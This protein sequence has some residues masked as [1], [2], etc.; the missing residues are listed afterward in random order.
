VNVENRN[1]LAIRDEKDRIIAEKD[2]RLNELSDNAI[3]DQAKAM[4]EEIIK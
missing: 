1:L 3:V 2:V 4:A